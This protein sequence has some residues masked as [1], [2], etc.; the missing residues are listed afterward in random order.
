M[1]S[2]TNVERHGCASPLCR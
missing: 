2:Q 1:R